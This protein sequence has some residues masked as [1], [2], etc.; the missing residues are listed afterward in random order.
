[1]WMYLGPL[2]ITGEFPDDKVEIRE[3]TKFYDQ[4]RETDLVARN[5]SVDRESG[6]TYVEFEVKNTF[7]P[8]KKLV[9]SIDDIKERLESGQFKSMKRVNREAE[10]ALEELRENA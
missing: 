3:N 10:E 1:M 2:K 9:F 7:E 6:M 4:K 8:R 5:I